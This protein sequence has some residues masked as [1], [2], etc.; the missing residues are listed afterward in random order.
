ME[1]ALMAYF[2]AVRPDIVHAHFATKACALAGPCQHLKIPLVVSLR[3]VDASRSLNEPCWQQAYRELF[4][5]TSAVIL[6]SEEMRERLAPYV[7]DKV[8]MITIHAGKNADD[9]IFRFR[10]GP[11]R[12]YV[13]IGRLIE[14]KGH[15]DAVRAIAHA[16]AMGAEVIL[17]VIAEGRDRTALEALIQEKGLQD[18]VTLVGSLSHDAVKA[19]LDAADGFLLACKTPPSGDKEGI[20]NVLKEAQLMG[21]PIVSTN[22]AGIPYV[23]PESH[24]RWLAPEGDFQRLGELV[25]ELSK[26]SDEA[27]TELTRAGRAHIETHFS[28][29][30]EVD[31]HLKLYKE[32]LS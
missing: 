13:T 15:L 26:Q 28:L 29:A 22:H 5:Q 30:V 1:R 6:V 16:R 31:R 9:Y 4:T 7:P 12:Q 19:E 27:L 17:R 25:V 23:V 18:C 20:P 14:K 11:I 32:I 10:G 21:L 2:D 24:R 8:P 3:G